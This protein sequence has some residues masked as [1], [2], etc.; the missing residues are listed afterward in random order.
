MFLF[1]IGSLLKRDTSN[2]GLIQP[3][4]PEVPSTAFTSQP[5]CSSVLRRSLSLGAMQQKGYAVSRTSPFAHKSFV[6]HCNRIPTGHLAIKQTLRKR[7]GGLPSKSTQSIANIP[8]STG[9]FG[10]MPC[11]ARSPRILDATDS[12]KKGQAVEEQNGKETAAVVIWGKQ[13]VSTCALPH[14]F[15]LGGSGTKGVRKTRNAS[16]CL[17]PLEKNNKNK[18][19]ISSSNLDSL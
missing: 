12:L 19:D 1:Q 8:E 3:I 9:L 17:S 5:I 10:P 16:I 4:N 6:E 11:G 13:H 14:F 7:V 15:T 18:T 2:Q